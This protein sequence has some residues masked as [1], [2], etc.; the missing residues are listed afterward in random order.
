MSMFSALRRQITSIDLDEVFSYSTTKEVRM[1]DRRLGM[2]CWAIRII[3][4]AYVAGALAL[5]E[6][7]GYFVYESTLKYAT[8][9]NS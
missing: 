5:V 8:L 6:T 2:L 1:L 3:V 9:N 4:F 7:P